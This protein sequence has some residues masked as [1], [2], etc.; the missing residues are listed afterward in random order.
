MGN[1]AIDSLGLPEDL[2]EAGCLKD[3]LLKADIE[4]G[5]FDPFGLRESLHARI[6]MALRDPD[7]NEPLSPR[8]QKTR[9]QV[10]TEDIRA[11][12]GQ[13]K[14][15]N[16]QWQADGHAKPTR[17]HYCMTDE[18]FEKAPRTSAKSMQEVLTA[19]ENRVPF[20]LSADPIVS[21]QQIGDIVISPSRLS[22]RLIKNLG[23]GDRLAKNKDPGKKRHNK[24][25]Q[26]E[27]KEEI[28]ADIKRTLQ[29][30]E[31][32]PP[33]PG[34][35]ERSAY[36]FFRIT[37]GPKTGYLLGVRQ[38]A[39]IESMLVVDLPGAKRSIDHMNDKYPLEQHQLADIQ[40]KLDDIDYKLANEWE[41]VKEN[42]LP[43]LLSEL[44]EIIKQLEFVIDKDKASLLKCVETAKKQLAGKNPGAARACMNVTKRTRLITNRQKA[45]PE[46]LPYL[47]AD[48]AAMQAHLSR[49]QAVAQKLYSDVMLRKDAGIPEK[50]DKDAAIKRLTRMRD[51]CR[52]SVKFEPY[53]SFAKKL[54]VYLTATIE[55][56]ARENPDRETA[57][58]LY[59][60]AVVVSKAATFEGFL[61]SFYEK[62]SVHGEQELNIVPLERDLDKASEEFNELQFAKDVYTN[63]YHHIWKAERELVVAIKAKLAEYKAIVEDPNGGADES[64]AALKK[65]IAEIKGLILAFDLPGKVRAVPIFTNGE[66][67]ISPDRLTK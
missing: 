7:S 10:I 47:K 50:H 57:K 56:L 55:N 65:N 38:I 59:V 21:A 53:L 15:A 66:K 35:G 43:K 18:E 23:F 12:I 8:M 51:E 52:G 44:A 6:I 58:N 16:M 39:G 1:T 25:E 19:P 33:V 27:A 3:I 46:I 2:R 20:K 26:L 13:M 9:I 32:L 4:N 34:S 14:Y 42:E 36:R 49:E 29:K 62:L 22:D 67:P 48:Q 24:L 40:V 28:I 64:K 30:L 17:S 54:D 45:I 60:R 5:N 63:E 11:C 37:S 61:L 31:P 41:Q